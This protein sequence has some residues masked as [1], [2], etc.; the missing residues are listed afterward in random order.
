M[1]GGRPRHSPRIHRCSA[2][3]C[4]EWANEWHMDG[5]GWVPLCRAHLPAKDVAAE[6]EPQ[7]TLFADAA[8]MNRDGSPTGRVTR[9]APSTSV[10]AARKTG[11][12]SQRQIILAAIRHRPDGMTSIE[13]AAIMPLTKQGGPQVSN[14]AAS[15]LGELWE[16]GEVTV[17]R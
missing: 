13:A 10:A 8:T 12:S 6:P 7:G 5:N 14:R 11:A 16:L 4:R 17:L 15:R 1:T 3:E 9:D 2:P